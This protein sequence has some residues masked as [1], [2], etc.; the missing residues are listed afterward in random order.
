MKLLNSSKDKIIIALQDYD[1]TV[2]T[3]TPTEIIMK[4][5]SG[6]G[7]KTKKFGYEDM[8]AMNNMICK[9]MGDIIEERNDLRKFE[10]QFLEEAL[11]TI[12]SIN[13]IVGKWCSICEWSGNDVEAFYCRLCGTELIGQEE[14]ECPKCGNAYLYPSNTTFCDSCGTC[15][16]RTPLK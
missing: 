16:V 10:E 4:Y 9:I 12:E 2:L 15:L 8:I 1:Q 3:V 14:F 13:D 11:V 7:H 6:N 5:K